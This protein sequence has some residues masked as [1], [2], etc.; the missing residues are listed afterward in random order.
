MLPQIHPSIR[1]TLVLC[2]NEETQ[3]D[4]VFTIDSPVSLSFLMPR[5]VAGERPCHT[6]SAFQSTLADL[7]VIVISGRL[8]L[9]TVREDGES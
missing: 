9:F 1:H 3:R 5:M 2:Q 7:L 4:A 8:A 6:P